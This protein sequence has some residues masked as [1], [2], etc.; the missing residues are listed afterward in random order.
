MKTEVTYVPR[1]EPLLL[2][3]DRWG[4]RMLYGHYRVDLDGGFHFRCPHT[5]HADTVSVS[6]V[7]LDLNPHFREALI[8]QATKAR[9]GSTEP[10]EGES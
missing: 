3:E 6:P 5:A 1:D 8:E 9:A 2:D 10:D 7:D 4:R